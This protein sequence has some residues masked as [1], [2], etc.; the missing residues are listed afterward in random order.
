M[1]IQAISRLLP[2][3]E[4]GTTIDI[5]LVTYIKMEMK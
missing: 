2:R 1:Y 4:M 3:I 5:P